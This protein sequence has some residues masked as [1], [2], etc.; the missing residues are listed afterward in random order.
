MAEKKSKEKGLSIPKILRTVIMAVQGPIC[1]YLPIKA[2]LRVCVLLVVAVDRESRILQT[3][4]TPRW[5]GDR[6]LVF[7]LHKICTMS[8]LIFYLTNCR[9]GC[10]A[11]G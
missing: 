6:R 4:D 1:F 3:A 10:A 7:P 2:V 5:Q 11:L 9:Q 8:L